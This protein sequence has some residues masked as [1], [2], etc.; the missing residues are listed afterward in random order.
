MRVYRIARKRHLDD[1]TG[2]G[3]K[4]FGGRWNHRGAAIL[5]ASETRSLAMVE[6][7][8]HVSWM[9]A[10]GDLGMA[11]LEIANEIE[12]ESLSPAD[13]PEDWRHYPGP[14]KL[15]DLGSGWVHSKRSLLLRVP[16][17]VVEQEH[18]ILINPGHSD[19]GRVTVLEVKDLE[20]DRRLLKQ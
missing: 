17:A 10:P 15:A 9:Q 5:Y 20:F 4:T 6:F 14:R 13:L 16:S 2:V 12:P 18:N 11:T 1:L 7:L 3:A 8:V 19:I